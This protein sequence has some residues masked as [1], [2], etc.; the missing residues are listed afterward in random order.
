M[1]EAST[2]VARAPNGAVAASVAL[3]VAA[4]GGSAGH[5][6]TNGS[7]A[8]HDGAAN[9][10]GAG[11]GA[12]NGN[13]AG[14]H[15][16]NPPGLAPAVALPPDSAPP[17][18]TAPPDEDGPLARAERIWRA[19]HEAL[20]R[21]LAESAR[22]LTHARANERAVRAARAA[23]AS[24]LAILTAQLEA[25]R[26]AHAVTRATSARLAA[27]L[28]TTRAELT[29]AKLRRPDIQRRAHA[30]A[31]AA[32]VTGPAPNSGRLLADLDAAAAALRL[33]T[34]AEPEAPPPVAAADAAPGAP[35]VAALP[36][37]SNGA[38]PLALD[39]AA[40]P[41]T[42]AADTQRRLRRALVEFARADPLAA[43]RLLIALLPAQAA[44]LD[45]PLSYDLTV[46]G[47][48][49]FAV[50]VADKRADVAR[51]RKPRR[52]GE[53]LFHLRVEALALAELLAGERAR[54]G[55]FRGAARANR[56]KRTAGL[57]P[58][59]SAK[60]SL[61]DAVRA[62]AR[63]DPELVYAALPFVV[64]AEWTR[65]H[66]FTVAQEVA[67]RTWFVTARDG[68]PLA[69]SQDPPVEPPDATVTL[70]AAAF[71]ALLRDEPPAAGERPAVRGDHAAVA[72]LKGWTDRARGIR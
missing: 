72:A 6:A 63:L 13:G 53:A 9:G 50:S 27:D 43:G 58:L 33:T 8:R 20:E 15:A 10:N 46:R 35:R 56:R 47:L 48:G 68:E 39:G 45:G 42:H 65:G 40:A 32:A 61:A 26:I 36:G 41:H 54:I 25:E 3:A 67:H 49:T 22:A 1:S 37:A 14:R 21:R 4:N 62:G 29:A 66:A 60:L 5:G 18:W 11:H 52:R 59:A 2:S 31:E 44:V 19:R 69:V 70:T 30:L 64:D 51:L 28:A 16:A 23:D 57:A 17:A 12:A 34:P 71:D 38:A 55:R 7:G 24:T